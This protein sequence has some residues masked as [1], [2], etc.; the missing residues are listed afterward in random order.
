MF[1]NLLNKMFPNPRIYEIKQKDK[2]LRF[3]PRRQ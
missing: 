2:L 3:Y 1:N